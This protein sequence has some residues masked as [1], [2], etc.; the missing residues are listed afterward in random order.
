MKTIIIFVNTDM[1]TEHANELQSLK[2]V[3]HK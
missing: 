1:K 2:L 3:K